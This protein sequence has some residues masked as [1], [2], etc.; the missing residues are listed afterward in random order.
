M[1]YGAFDDSTGS[2]KFGGLALLRQ[3]VHLIMYDMRCKLQRFCGSNSFSRVC[4]RNAKLHLLRL[5]GAFA[6][7]HLHL[8]QRAIY[9]QNRR[10]R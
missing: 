8:L 6:T 4:Q 7:Q 1:S 3:D 2:E 10:C 9:V 5:V